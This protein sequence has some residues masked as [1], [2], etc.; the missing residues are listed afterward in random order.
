MARQN[1]DE[2][3]KTDPRRTALVKRIGSRNADGMRVEVN[4]LLLD[5]KGGPV[6]LKEFKFIE[7]VQDWIDCGLAEVLGEMVRI[8]GADAYQEFFEK[9]KENG[10]KGGRPKN[11]NEPTETQNNPTVT[12]TN[13]NNPSLSSSFSL[14][15][16]SSDS[17]SVSSSVSNSKSIR[18]SGE[19]HPLLLLWNEHCGSLPKAKSC[20]S[21][22]LKKIRLRWPEQTAEAWALTITRMAKSAFCC[23]KGTT[24][25]RADFDFLLK[26][27][28][29]AKVNE[30][31]YDNGNG[32]TRTAQT[33]KYDNLDALEKKWQ[34]AT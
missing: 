29:W 24:G 1:I 5:H 15:L 6:P 13:P 19:A 33:A 32:V 23:G 25:W 18:A 14:S 8:A 28:T 22:R 2:K 9:Q 34:E 26:P 11:P 21:S 17:S 31:K 3:W 4:W 30:G 16:S 20:N 7:N 12:Q 10:K 27:D